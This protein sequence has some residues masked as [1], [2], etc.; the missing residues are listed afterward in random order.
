MTVL[1]ITAGVLTVA[2]TIYGGVSA[3]QSGKA[4][5]AAANEAA[6]NALT[7]SQMQAD[8]ARQQAQAEAD[9]YSRQARLEE[10]RA[11][12]EQIQGEQ[13]AEKRSRQLASSVGSLYANYAG[14]GLLVDGNPSDTLGA[15]LRTEVAEG[16]ADI[17]T[18]RDNTAI[19]VWTRQSNALSLKT[20][21]ANALTAGHNAASSYLFQ[22]LAEAQSNI[23]Q[24]KIAYRSGVNS[25][26]GSSISATGQTIGTVVSGVET[27]NKYGW[28]FK[29]T[30]A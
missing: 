12:I 15:A 27:Y 7:A 18:I 3:Y 23:T 2:G 8:A 25:L 26:I 10:A 11:G 17:S 28:G 21:A 22:G 19:N 6:Q 13:E 16:Q 9:E 4:Q 14:N 30:G 29:K 20:S 1:V 24:G 5:Q